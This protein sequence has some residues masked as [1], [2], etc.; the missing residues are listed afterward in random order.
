MVYLST[1]DRVV[2]LQCLLVMFKDMG[3]SRTYSRLVKSMSRRYGIPYGRL[4]SDPYLTR[5]MVDCMS[6]RRDSEFSRMPRRGRPPKGKKALPFS[7]RT[8]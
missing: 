3:D 2:A 6:E 5:D 7:N 4:W 1:R 8:P